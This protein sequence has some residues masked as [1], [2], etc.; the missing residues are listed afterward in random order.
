[1]DQK[2]GFFCILRVYSFLW[3]YSFSFNL[4][5]EGKVC[6]SV[7]SMTFSNSLFVSKPLFPLQKK[8]RNLTTSVFIS[9]QGLE[10]N[11]Q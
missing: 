5:R 6:F 9:L 10:V 2:F 1:M 4:T 7:I 8:S 3:V 11:I